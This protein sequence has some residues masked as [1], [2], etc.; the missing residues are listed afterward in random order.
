MTACRELLLPADHH[1]SELFALYILATMFF[2]N[3]GDLAGEWAQSVVATE[4]IDEISIDPELRSKPI[5]LPVWKL[6]KKQAHA[7]KMRSASAKA[8]PRGFT[9]GR[10][11]V[12]ALMLGSHHPRIASINNAVRIVMREQSRARS[13]VMSD[14][15][16]FKSVAHLWAAARAFYDLADDAITRMIDTA[17]EARAVELTEDVRAHVHASARADDIFQLWHADNLKAILS[18]AE[19]FRIAGEKQK[20]SGALQALLPEGTAFACPAA[21]G[22]VPGKLNPAPPP[23]WMI[24]EITAV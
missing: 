5:S 20:A 2:P 21:I 22:I 12:V 6:L 3:D 18:I 24:D 19:A 1:N 14:W 13:A 16:D 10:I 9:A 11:L 15:T 7:E 4:L 8:A 17:M 23:S